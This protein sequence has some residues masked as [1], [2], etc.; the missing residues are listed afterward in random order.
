MGDGVKCPLVARN[1]AVSPY[2]YTAIT[3]SALYRWLVR[4]SF[5][6]SRITADSLAINSQ[7]ETHLLHGQ[8][9]FTA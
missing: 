3:A 7:H 9:V 5:S 6:K 2:E 4:N 8:R 1:T